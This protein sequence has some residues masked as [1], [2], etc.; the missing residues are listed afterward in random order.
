M[1]VCCKGHEFP[2]YTHKSCKLSQVNLGCNP[3]S[4]GPVFSL[5][6][7]GISRL[8]LMYSTLHAIPKREVELSTAHYLIKA[9][10]PSGA[11]AFPKA[12]VPITE[13]I[14]IWEGT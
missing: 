12:A 3:S 8:R 14:H 4:E 11:K 10:F 5:K 2:I 1:K 13:P 7:I 6:K 9:A